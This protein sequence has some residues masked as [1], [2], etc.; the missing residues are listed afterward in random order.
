MQKEQKVQR[1]CPVC[2]GHGNSM[3]TNSMARIDALDMSYSVAACVVCESVFA[4]ILPSDA[5][6][7]EYYSR[8]SK[9]DLAPV[10]PLSD[11]AK[12]HQ[13][14]TRLIAA[15]VQQNV[16]TLDIGCG[17]GHLL[18]CLREQG[19]QSLSGIDPAPN[20]GAVAAAHYGLHNIRTGFFDKST[21]SASYSG[22]DLVCLSAVLEHMTDPHGALQ[23]LLAGMA[24]GSWLAVEVPDLDAFDGSTGEPY[25]ELSLEHINYFSK[26][27][28]GYLFDSLGC[29][30]VCCEQI[31]LSGGGSL[32]ILARKRP[33]I[34]VKHS[35]TNDTT[36]MLE[37]LSASKGTFTPRLTNLLARLNSPFVVY[38]AGS[39]TA[40]LLPQLQQAKKLQ[41]CMGIVDNN[42]N[43]HGVSMGGIK[44][45]PTSWLEVCKNCTIVISS[46]KSEKEIMKSLQGIQCSVLSM[47]AENICPKEIEQ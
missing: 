47:Y 10:N 14:L 11:T 3:Y 1:L 20:A 26:R 42:T 16:A 29:E 6:Y 36:I 41:M 24:A 22:F 27:S 23:H 40:R 43:L 37:Y 46:Y 25:G 31:R 18:F 33:T 34:A 9:Y 8:F 19:F 32:L 35:K 17:S 30:T 4:S 45:H 28:L 39:H 5:V 13:A 12:V 7:S 21:P 38:G 15:H 2:G 44:I